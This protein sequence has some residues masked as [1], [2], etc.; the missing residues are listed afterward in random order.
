MNWCAVL[1]GASITSESTLGRDI[2]KS[3]SASED[4]SKAAFLIH[5]G[6]NQPIATFSLYALLQHNSVYVNKS[7]QVE[8]R[9]MPMPYALMI[10][11][12]A[13]ERPQIL[14][15]LRHVFV[16]ATRRI[17][18]IS[19][20][21]RVKLWY[22]RMKRREDDAISLDPASLTKVQTCIERFMKVLLSMFGL[23]WC[24]REYGPSLSTFASHSPICFV[25]KN[26]L[27][28]ILLRRLSQ[29]KNLTSKHGCF[30]PSS[31][32]VRSLS[33]LS[34][35]SRRIPVRDWVCLPAQK[36][37]SNPVS[38]LFAH[39]YRFGTLEPSEELTQNP[40]SGLLVAA[41]IL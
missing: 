18:K 15:K 28:L 5:M 7:Y 13:N 10:S 19:R 27:T 11:L 1:P 4:C 6:L 9:I 39:E 2:G 41:L 3:E 12:A 37:D 24:C 21:Q 16:F 38:V 20:P 31:P 26:L 36:W 35:R 40:I 32:S 23:N 30:C 22:N 14:H 17:S 29:K 33:P 8:L 34:T 25:Q